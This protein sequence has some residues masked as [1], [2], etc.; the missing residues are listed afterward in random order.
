MNDD[1]IAAHK[2]CI[3]HK[4]KLLKDEK[5]GCF[6]CI[7]IFKPSEI[8]FWIIDPLETAVC[9]YCGIDSVIGEYSGYPI[10][11]EFLAKMHEVWF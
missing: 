8:V 5:C 2:Y 10:T 4:E 3:N 6:Y 1:V 11:E 7:K 9:P